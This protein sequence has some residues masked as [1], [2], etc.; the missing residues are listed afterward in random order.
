M[1]SLIPS[2]KVYFGSQLVNSL[3]NLWNSLIIIFLQFL[4][5]DN[6]FVNAATES[7]AK[8]VVNYTSETSD[9]VDKMIATKTNGAN[10]VKGVQVD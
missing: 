10:V 5:Y 2:F 1:V 6:I 8:I 9:L 4:V 3:S 7:G